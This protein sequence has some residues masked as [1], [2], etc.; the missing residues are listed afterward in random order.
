MIAHV[1]AATEQ[2]GRVVLQLT[3]GRPNRVALEA[4]ILVAKAFESEVESLFVED[5]GLVDCAGF[6][7][8][9]E[10]SLHGRERRPLSTDSMERELRNMAAAIG[11]DL[12]A[13]A[14]RAEVPLRQTI[15]RD[16]P[17]A[18][19]A[20]ACAQRGPWNV[21]ALGNTVEKAAAHLIR[22]LFESVLDSTG[23]IL[24][25]PRARKGTGPII[26]VVEH[27][28]RLE[29]MLRAAQRLDVQEKGTA[30][31]ALLVG[32]SDEVIV[33][34]EEQ[35]R[36]VLGPEKAV[37]FVRTVVTEGSERSLAEVLRRLHGS[38]VIG[39]FGSRLAPPDGDM[40]HLLSNLESPLFLIR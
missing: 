14:R 34:M 5:Q 20:K 4:A 15:V 13:L 18:A 40:R 25:G 33:R 31:I 32:E 35:S 37:T 17:I 23:V 22:S 16:D 7:F 29:G 2:R 26:V 36:L 6:P 28:D 39:Q 3:S 12:S 19:L 1:A 8:A 21:I 24:A 10:I 9:C 11:R 27:V 38:F 30:V